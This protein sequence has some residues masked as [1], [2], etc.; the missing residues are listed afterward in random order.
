MKNKVIAVLALV[1]VLAMTAGCTAKET[2]VVESKSGTVSENAAAPTTEAK[3]EP[4]IDP[5]AMTLESIQKKGKIISAGKSSTEKFG[6][7][8]AN[9]Y[10]FDS[11]PTITFYTFNSVEDAESTFE[12]IKSKVLMD[13]TETD[14]T[15]VGQRAEAIGLP[16]IQF[17]YLTG[18]MIVANDDFIG[19]PGSDKGPSDTQ[20]TNNQNLHD[21]IVKYW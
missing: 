5:N 9:K 3:S 21:E 10:T 7:I 12:Y 1:L 14:N 16:Y 8:T 2:A 6:E 19:D 4:N 18:N 11:M 17:Y 20:N 13:T 15:V